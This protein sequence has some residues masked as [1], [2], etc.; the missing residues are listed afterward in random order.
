MPARPIF[1][2]SCEKKSKMP[3]I[4]S[5]SGGVQIDLITGE[6][7]PPGMGFRFIFLEVDGKCMFGG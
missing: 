2:G 1:V 5:L 4:L 3:P 7:G 6:D